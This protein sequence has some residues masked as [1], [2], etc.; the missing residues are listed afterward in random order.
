MLVKIHKS[1]RQI[2]AIC[3]K[4]LLGKTFEEDNREI[5]IKPHFFQGENKT[6]EEVAEI[7]EKASYDDSTFNIVGKESIDVAVKTGLIKQDGITT[8]QGVPIALVLL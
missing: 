3:D 7:I 6:P 5:K 1:Y 4:D 2:V 8:I